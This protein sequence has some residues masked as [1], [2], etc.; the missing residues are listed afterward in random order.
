MI[1]ANEALN[2]IT[3]IHRNN[4]VVHPGSNAAQYV[5]DVS[6]DGGASWTTDIGPITNNPSIDNVSVNG[7][8]P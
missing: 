5:Y 8:F 1:D 6:K 2:T 3:F 7:R 4:P